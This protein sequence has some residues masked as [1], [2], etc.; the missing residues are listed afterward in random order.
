MKIE[1]ENTV[2]YALF[3]LIIIALIGVAVG[4]FMLKCWLAKWVFGM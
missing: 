2:A 4:G 1:W 3:A